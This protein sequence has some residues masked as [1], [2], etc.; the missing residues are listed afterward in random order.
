MLLLV[1]NFLRWRECDRMSV[2]GPLCAKSR[3]HVCSNMIKN[4]YYL[5]SVL[6]ARIH[7]ACAHG[8][9]FVYSECY[10]RTCSP[11]HRGEELNWVYH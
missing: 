6:R 4:T 2:K 7:G 5:A 9:C 10:V 1:A 8:V 3:L 11:V